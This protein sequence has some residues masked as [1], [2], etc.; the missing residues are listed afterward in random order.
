MRCVTE[1]GSGS[2]VDVRVPA[3]P[4]PLPIMPSLS[5]DGSCSA[6]VSRCPV[7]GQR[8]PRS[9]GGSE[10]VSMLRIPTWANGHG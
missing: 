3:A 2:M 6:L 10:H 4:D 9:L 8:R 1:G 5:G 7:G